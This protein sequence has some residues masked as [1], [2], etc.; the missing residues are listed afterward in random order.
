MY[1]PI[2][3]TLSLAI[4]PAASR[5]ETSYSDPL[6]PEGWAWAQ[7]KSGD[8]ADFNG[9][10]GKAFDPHR[11]DD[12][13]NVCRRVPARFLQTIL[14]ESPWKEQIARNRVHL[15]GVW[16]DGSLDVMG[17]ELLSGLEI[18]GSTIAGDFDLRDSHWT[19]KIMISSS[20]FKGKFLADGLR[21]DSS[22]VISGSDEFDDIVSL[23]LV[24]LGGDLDLSSSIF[25][26]VIQADTM[27][28]SG[29]I[30]ARNHATFGDAL[31][32]T[33]FKTF[34]EIN[35]SDSTLA[36]QASMADIDVG[37]DVWLSNSKLGGALYM[38]HAKIGDSLIALKT[39][40]AGEFKACSSSAENAIFLSNSVFR[41]DVCLNSVVTGGLEM[42]GSVVDG[43]LDL[44][45]IKARNHVLL[46]NGARFNG[47]INLNNASVGGLLDFQNAT[48]SNIDLS[49]ASIRNLRLNGVGWLCHVE[50]T[51]MDPTPSHW[52]LG[53]ADWR[54]ADCGR[55]ASQPRSVIILLN[56]YA[57][58]FQD[59]VD[60]WP[61]T[62][63]LEGF[64]YDRIGGVGLGAE[65][66]MSQRTS[67][68]WNAWLA[69]S[70]VF[71]PQPYVQLGDTLIAAGRR[72]DGET[73]LLAGRERERDDLWRRRDWH[74]REWL[75][76]GF[77]SWLRLT[78]LSLV[79]GYGIGIHT[80]R[81]VLW[82]IALVI[83]GA[84]VLG[85]SPFACARGWAWRLGASLHRLL[86]IMELDKEFQDF[87]EG[88][89]SGG[90]SRRPTRF[91]RV[92]FSGIALA[93]WVLGF[94]LIAAMG[95]LI[96]K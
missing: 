62:A 4:L 45:N 11:S 7:I 78:F 95:G 34:G 87:F 73:I 41:G 82:V 24:R 40:V 67:G 81:V 85:L 22:L 48:T 28:I 15:Q 32:L 21:S 50:K 72:D 33:G 26:G 39:S 71:S 60:A 8:T 5:A 54:V 58:A 27:N 12:S 63:D 61:P 2:L 83:L 30:F 38:Q 20:V 23:R 70:R 96:A 16:I 59:D 44:E 25:H 76:H 1:L 36:K 37:T 35:L 13:S 74:S 29:S 92:F 80:F 6:T 9:H 79:V 3:L 51:Q 75:Y 47:Q 53:S 55:S 93:G 69:R 17:A 66:E 65:G 90:D 31:N 57:Q 77:P 86:P 19:R 94:F 52:K 43:D 64:R 56:T 46:R 88:K 14:T 10:C 49:N 89:L 68:V 91:Q 84:V 18:E 42:E